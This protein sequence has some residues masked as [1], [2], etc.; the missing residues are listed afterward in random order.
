MKPSGLFCRVNS[1]ATSGP[2]FSRIPICASP[3][4]EPQ[5]PAGP[6]YSVISILSAMVAQRLSIATVPWKNAVA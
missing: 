4:M 5:P 6:V 3:F 2:A 1:F